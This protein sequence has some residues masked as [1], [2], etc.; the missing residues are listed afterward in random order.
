MDVD[1]AVEISAFEMDDPLEE[2]KKTFDADD[3]KK[4]RA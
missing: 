4:A 2:E 1:E 3:V